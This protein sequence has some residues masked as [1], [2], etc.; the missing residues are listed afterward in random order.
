MF[1]AW[2]ECGG[3]AVLV[4]LKTG[5]TVTA[6]QLTAQDTANNIGE[7]IPAATDGAIGYGVAL[8]T[9]THSTTQGDTEGVVTC[10][11]RGDTI[12]RAKISDG[13]TAIDM[14]ILTNTSQD[15]TGLT[16]TSADVSANDMSSG[17]VWRLLPGGST[18]E[19]R[20][21]TTDTAGTSIVVT[22]PF[23]SIEV[24]DQFLYAPWSH[25]G[26]GGG[27]LTATTNIQEADGD[28]ASGT[29]FSIALARILMFTESDS[30]VDFKNIEHAMNADNLS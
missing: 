27:N 1:N 20:V 19:Y 11:M 22:V 17:T 24:G 18:G 12:V 13:S 28:V 10:D 2:H 16:I 14:Q 26:D 21:I 23:S 3:A 30:Y 25:T 4:K 9:G 5:A 7:V 8:D 6:G 29:G 15:T